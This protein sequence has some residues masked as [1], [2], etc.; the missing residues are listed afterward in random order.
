MTD[1]LIGEVGLGLL[2]VGAIA[3]V[4]ELALMAFWGLRTARAVEVLSVRA[5][6]EQ[7]ALQADLQRLREAMDETKRLWQ[8]YRRA[9]RWLQHPLVIALV[10]SYRRRRAAR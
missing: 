4:V 7:L 1:P 10:G 9:L 5:Q 2:A 8:P 3:I 6:D